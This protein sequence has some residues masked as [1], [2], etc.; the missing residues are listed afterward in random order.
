[1]KRMVSWSVALWLAA[2]GLS[3]AQGRPL[4]PDPTLVFEGRMG[5][6][7]VADTLLDCG[8]AACGG[9]GGQ[10]CNGRNAS[11]VTLDDV[12]ES[13]SLRV[14]H[15]RLNWAASTSVAANPD[16]Q[17]TLTPPG[18]EPLPVLADPMLSERFVD[19]A[20]PSDC[21]VA[22]LL[23]PVE[24]ACDLGFYSNFADITEAIEAHHA[25]GGSLNGLWRLTDVEVPGANDGDPSTAIAALGSLTIGAWSLLL[26]YEDEDALPVRRIY[27]Y[28]G[29]ELNSGLDRR[30]FPRGF[31]APPDPEMDLTLMVLEGDE[32]VR[33][34]QLSVNGRQVSDACNPVDNL[35]NSTVN[36]GRAD[37]SCRRRVTGVDLDRFNVVGAVRAGDE[38]AEILLR[39]PRG[40]GLITP[41][42]QVFTNWMVLAF[43]HLLPDFQSVKPEKEA[44][45]PSGRSVAPGDIIS[46]R[47]QVENDGDAAATNVIVRD[48]L[49]PEIEYVVG[50]LMLDGRQVADG[51]GGAFPL[52]AGLNL[53]SLQ[54]VGPSIEVGER[55]RLIFEARGRRDVP[56]GAEIRNVAEISADLIDPLATPAVLHPVVVPGGG[57]LPEPDA[58]P[59]AEPLIDMAPPEI[60]GPPVEPPVDMALPPVRDGGPNPCGPGT[61]LGADG[62]CESVCGPGTRWDPTCDPAT[63][64]PENQPPCDPG[65]SGGG[66]GASDGCACS[67]GNGGPGGFWI[68]LLALAFVRRRRR[69]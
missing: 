47:I 29:F 18:G 21:Q 40:D 59:D 43:D 33:G 11:E 22:G 37:G 19:G 34:D 58:E 63:C 38:E 7:A 16:V 57:L 60:D 68:A 28:Q 51:P 56:D 44:D 20:P 52:A 36:T 61:R 62:L 23:C 32:G 42:E 31:L 46:Y 4:G 14:V 15:A 50:S 69:R 35:F 2:P 27:Y 1:M 24:P 64:V 10:N 26:V 65:A 67:V 49:A 53:N 30:L 25:G 41:G 17:V 45:P 54:P 8:A 6:S 55:H 5:Y 12:P 13:P 48:P 9:V 39:I 3:W 66:A